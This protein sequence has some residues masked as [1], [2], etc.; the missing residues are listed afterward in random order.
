[1]G[2]RPIPQCFTC[3]AQ[4]LRD[5]SS[6]FQCR[7]IS[8]ISA[9]TFPSGVSRRFFRYVAHSFSSTR[10]LSLEAISN[11]LN[12]KIK[13]RTLTWGGAAGPVIPHLRQVII[14][15]RMFR[16][17]RMHWS[18]SSTSSRRLMRAGIDIPSCQF[19]RNRVII[20]GN[21]VLCGSP[22]GIFWILHLRAH[23]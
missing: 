23:C 21:H 7:Q 10:V 8:G 1:M 5:S 17:A 9:T 15:V 20:S 3:P 14:G 6:E 16:A 19:D 4:Q 22:E 11:R 13:A 2:R 12:A 18:I